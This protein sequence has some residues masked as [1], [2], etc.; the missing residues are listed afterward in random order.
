MVLTRSVIGGNEEVR[1]SFCSVRVVKLTNDAVICGS[2]NLRSD[3]ESL[4]DNLKQENNVRTC[5]YIK[6]SAYYLRYQW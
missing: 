5:I 3:K 4:L 1:L 6:E 2:W